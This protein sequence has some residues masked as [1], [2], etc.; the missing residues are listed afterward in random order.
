MA[1]IRIV[2]SAGAINVTGSA[3]FRGT[4]GSTILYL[5]GSGQIGAGTTNPDSEFHIVGSGTRFVTLDR[6]G[7]RSY[8]LGVN[9]SG[10]FL[11]TDN[12]V[13]ADRIA[14]NHS[15]SVGIGTTGPLSLL[16]LRGSEPTIRIVDTDDSSTTLIGSTSGY[17]FIRPFSRDFRV[18]N[19]AGTGLLTVKTGGSVGIGTTNPVQ[20]LHVVGSIYQR[21]GDVITWNNG[22][23]Q[24]GAVSGYNLAFSTYDGVS[25]MVER[26]R[27]TSAGNVGIGVTNPAYKLEI[28]GKAY[29]STELQANTAVMNT[30]SGYASFGSNSGTTAV[31]VGRDA[32]LNDII[33]NAD[34]NVG[35]GITN[36]SQKFETTGKVKFRSY[37]SGTNTGTAT[38]TLSVD[39]SGNVI[40]TA[41]SSLTGTGTTNY[42]TKWSGT[43]ALTNSLLYDDGTN[44]GIGTTGPQ[45]VFEVVTPANNFA[46][47]GVAGLGV[48]QWTGI[49]FGYRENNQNY[50]KSAIVFER[51]DLTANDAQGKIHILN[52]P[53][54]SANS[55]TLSDARVTIAEGGNVGI[56]LT[57]PS[58]ALHINGGAASRSDVQVTYNALGTTSTD[59]A[60][61]GI[62]SAGAYIWNFENSPIYFGTNNNRR[63]DIT[64]DGNVGIGITTPA[65]RLSGRVLSLNDTG[66]NLQSSIELLRNG[67]SSGEIFVNSDNMVIGSYETGIPLVFRTQNNEHLRITSG[68]NVGI[69]T[70]NPVNKL[71]VAGGLTVASGASAGRITLGSGDTGIALYR[72]NTYDLVLSQDES[73]GNPLYLA[74]AGNVVVSIDSNNNSTSNKFIIGS[75]AV[76]SSNEL[77]SVEESGN[78]YISND[79]NVS[80]KITAREFHTTFVS[81]SII[82]QSGSTQFGNSSDDTHVFTGCIG[83]GTTP[84]TALT[85]NQDNVSYAGQLQIAASDYAQVTF[86]NSSALTPGASNRKASL[87][88]N[89]PNSRFEIAN[90]ITNGSLILQGSDSGGGNVGIGTDS[91]GGK[92]DITKET[93]G[94]QILRVRNYAASA[95]GNFTGNYAA[96]IRSAYDTGATGGALL[97]HTQEANNARPTMAVSDSNGVFTTFVNGKVGIGTAS[98]GYKLDV[99][100]TGRFSETLYYCRSEKL[101]KAD[102]VAKKIERHVIEEIDLKALATEDVCLACEG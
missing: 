45:K 58:Y 91:P 98:P 72:D 31:R 16:H 48:G 60:Q 1:D 17:S 89:I 10:T 46:S 6:S 25:A 95:T 15:G 63:V 43:T 75:N 26:M 37:G 33:I 12:T 81:A 35:I 66:V 5:T 65:V 78:V 47:V 71:H 23:A 14:L 27:V 54:G 62:Q 57:N 20:A 4:G 86:Y 59:G 53:Q 52:G 18:I 55:A 93:G 92:L 21:T 80:G 49:H 51:T 85:L 13:S 34:G 50:R 99:N 38:Y 79:L 11:V 29:A 40:E 73:S 19:D 7:T 70:T 22:D 8:D 68:G 32:S 44:V 28:S 30:T 39:S 61:F 84:R 101:A 83:V 69:G 42:I 88:Y 56:G 76:K 74:G 96:E 67:N 90:Q 94:Q 36:P 82:Y 41:N 102:K 77:F 24:I 97:V 64:A 2:P 9:S 87:I 100:G 3:D